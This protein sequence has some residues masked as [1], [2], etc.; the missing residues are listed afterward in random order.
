MAVA[1]LRSQ[2]ARRCEN[3]LLVGLQLSAG[4]RSVFEQRQG[5]PLDLVALG[6]EMCVDEGDQIG[7]DFVDLALIVAL[8]NQ[9]VRA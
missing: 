4:Q 7:E 1:P 5:D 6:D 8:S 3:L 2:S 9:E